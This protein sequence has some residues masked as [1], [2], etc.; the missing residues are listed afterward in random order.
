MTNPLSTPIKDSLYPTKEK[1]ESAL[2]RGGWN[3]SS[4]GWSRI[5]SRNNADSVVETAHICLFEGQW[6]IS[7]ENKGE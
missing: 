6:K 4:N 7:I 5:I 1:A 3:E 2:R